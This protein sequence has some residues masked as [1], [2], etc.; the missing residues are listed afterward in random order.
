MAAAK[1]RRCKAVQ[2]AA[3]EAAPALA[4]RAEG[5]G[6]RQREIAPAISGAPAPVFVG[7]KAPP[8]GAPQGRE[9]P[10]ERG[11]RPARVARQCDPAE[12]RSGRATSAVGAA[13]FA[14]CLAPQGAKTGASR[15][16]DA[17]LA[18][19]GD[20]AGASSAGA[21]FRPHHLGHRKLSLADPLE[22]QLDDNCQTQGR[23]NAP[24]DR[25]TRGREC[26][27]GQ[28]LGRKPSATAA[29]LTAPPEP[30]AGR[31][32]SAGQIPSRKPAADRR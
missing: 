4:G 8:V 7:G 26:G 19:R 10:R 2:A 1:G 17:A 25:C 9:T 18:A 12:G 5:R 3:P 28:A 29:S 31:Q 30:C 13:R 6:G 11:G 15:T 16:V 27:G 14:G 32:S 20:K 22:A 21:A 23:F 24:L